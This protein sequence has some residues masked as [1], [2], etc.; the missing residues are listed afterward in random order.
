VNG[1]FHSVAL[2]EDKC[3]GCTNCI[4]TCPTEAIRVRKGKARI[5]LERCIDCGECIRVCPSNAKIADTDPF[6]A[7][8]AFDY[9]VAVPAPSLYGQFPAPYTPDHILTGLKRLGFDD[10]F[11]AAFAAE[12]VAEAVREYGTAIDRNKP[13]ISSSCPAVVRLIQVRFPSL[14]EHVAKIMA[15]MEIAGKLVRLKYR[16]KKNLGI[17]FVTPCP[18]KR[19]SIKASLS[20]ERSSLDGAIAVKD[21]YIP[22]LR[23]ISRM[24]EPEPL[25]QAGFSG[26]GWAGSDGEAASIG[27]PRT[28]TVDGIHRVIEVLELLENGELKDVDFI[29]AMSCPGG[30]VGGPL[31]A[32]NSDVARARIR[33]MNRNYRP[34]QEKHPDMT[35]PR[36]AFIWEKVLQ[37]RP[38]MVLDENIAGALEKIKEVDRLSS[39]LPGLDCGACGSPSCR[40][41]AED[42]VRGTAEETDCIFVLRERIRKLTMEMVGLEEKLPP[43]LSPPDEKILP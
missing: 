31:N 34:P 39:T 26:I 23:E 3:R 13:V 33:G 29:E 2:R 30:C 36:S 24:S 28:L 43:S 27:I 11:E 20:V 25:S 14:I 41:L 6:Q 42:I 19:T 12:L 38:V 35:L 1:Y 32:V 21:I 7:I 17:F 9:A 37:S 5:I 8:K 40:S 10:V 22:L 15:P 4:S 18:A 16:D